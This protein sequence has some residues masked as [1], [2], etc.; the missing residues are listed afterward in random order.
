MKLLKKAKCRSFYN[1]RRTGGSK[2]HPSRFRSPYAAK[3]SFCGEYRMTTVEKKGHTGKHHVFMLHGGA[4]LLEASSQHRRMA[5]RFANNALRATCID[6]PLVPEHTAEVT[7]RVVVE[8]YLQL[9]RQYPDDIFHVFGDSAG[10]GLA[11]SLLMQLRD[12]GLPLPESTALS[13]PWLDVSMSNPEARYF[14]DLDICLPWEGLIYAGRKYAGSLGADSPLVS[15]IFG[16]MDNLGSILIFYSSK[17][18]L[19]ADCEKFARFTPEGTKIV[20]FKVNGL[21]H[22]FAMYPELRQGREAFRIMLEFFL[23]SENLSPIY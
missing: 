15:P 8:A 11:V 2:L 17:E 23:G 1:P 14:A 7:V 9:K 5:Q 4:Y 22:N 20:S 21:F 6:Y 19:T 18:A 3:E 16:S 13:S 12:M 10:G